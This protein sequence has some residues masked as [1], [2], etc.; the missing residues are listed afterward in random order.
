MHVLLIITGGI[1]AYKTPEL[2]RRLREQGMRVTCVVTQAAQQFVTPLALSAVSE[3]PVYDN[4][5]DQSDE[6]DMGHIRL[7]READAI[8]VAPATADFIAKVAM[9]LADDLGSALML[10]ADKP[11]LVAPAMNHRMWHNPATQRNVDRLRQDGHTLIDPA[12]GDMACGEFG[13]G[14]LPAIP[15]LVAAV[16]AHAFPAPKPL[17]GAHALITNGPTV[18]ALD[19]VR[20][21][22]N[23]SSGKQGWAIAQALIQAGARVTLV[24]GPTHLP[25]LGDQ[26]GSIQVDVTSAESMLAAVEAALPASIF[27]AV[28]AVADYRP[29]TVADQKMKKQATA[30]TLEFVPTPDILT[31]LCEHENRPQLTVGFAAETGDLHAKATAKRAK[32]GCDWLLANDV[33]A[34]PDIFGGDQNQ[35]LFLSGGDPETWPLQ[36]KPAVA[37]ALVQRL[38][39]HL[40]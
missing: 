28:A 25:H 21:V 2:V 32:K 27:I 20:Y 7:S 19:P 23:H 8:L 18:E 35:I 40:S 5:W 39:S 29:R 14:R 16:S 26:N 3:A 4:L 15:D 38:V 12:V 34:N 13:P 37:Q 1:A 30:L 11:A 10:A 33:G 6:R 36:S 24:S 9:G 22:S 31:T 17:A